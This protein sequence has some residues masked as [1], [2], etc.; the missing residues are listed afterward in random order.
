VYVYNMYM[1]KKL[2]E[3]EQSNLDA[4]GAARRGAALRL[5]VLVLVKP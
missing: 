2:G 3:R 1:M 5:L 4:D